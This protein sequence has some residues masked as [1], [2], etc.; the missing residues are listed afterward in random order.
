MPQRQ[1]RGPSRSI[2]PVTRPSFPP[3][4]EYE[5]FLPRLWSTGVVTNGGPYVRELERRIAR[6]LP[7]R[8]VAAVSNGTVAIQLALR[9]VGGSKGVVITTP[10]TYA[11]TTTA[12]VWQGFTPQFVDIDRETFVMDH[13]LVAD[14]VDRD[15]VGLLP[16]QVFGNT[17]GSRELAALAKE[18]GWWTVFD[19]AH[20]FGVRTSRGSLF[21][22]GD[23]STLSFHATKSFHT[24]EGGAVVTPIRAVAR[25]VEL[26][27]AFG[28]RPTGDVSEPGINGKLSEPHA[29]MGLVNLRYV[30]R[31][32]RAREARVRLYRDL[33][34]SL[35][36]IEFQRL[37]SARHNHIY[38]PVLFAT[39]RQRDRVYRHL[40]RSG[41]RT[42]VY[43][44]VAANRFGFVPRA[45]RRACP[46]A[47]E[48][49]GRVLCLPLYHELPPGSVRRI[50]DGVRE[51]LG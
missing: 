47:H 17:A 36:G 25:R 27:R 9:A 23:A 39:K 8:N 16:V 5:S 35:P 50:V 13:H 26:L 32:I 3:L 22:L 1:R 33:L 49:S 34:S 10:F 2:I 12:L 4:S 11:A 29:A 28:L 46:V 37:E 30:D 19:S 48:I 6:Y 41:I 40:Y 45:L 51:A 44:P 31:W 24:F 38:M 7:A 42:R 21:D 43:Y 15:V 18:R 20:C 14:R